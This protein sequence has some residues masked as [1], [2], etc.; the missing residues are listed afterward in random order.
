MGNQKDPET[1][2][3][4]KDF[5]SYLKTH[6]PINE[7]HEFIKKRYKLK[8]HTEVYRFL[9]NCNPYGIYDDFNQVGIV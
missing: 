2:K 1:E 3:N 8:T 4:V 9:T 5:I 6:G 7:A